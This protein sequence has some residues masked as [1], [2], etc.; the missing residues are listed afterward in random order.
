MARRETRLRVDSEG[1]VE[2]VDPGFDS[3]ALLRELEPGFK[4]RR[5][6]LPSFTS[7]RFLA[8]RSTGCGIALRRLGLEGE[9]T[10]WEAHA[11]V[12]LKSG[13][14]ATVRR[15]GEGEASLLALKIELARRVLSMCRLC[16]HRCHVNR[17]GSEVGVCRLG[18]SATVAEHF[19]HVAE[20]APLNPS[21]VLN[22]YG[23]GLRCRFCQQF[24]L[25]DTA[26]A[27]GDK[28]DAQL[29]AALETGGAR[30]LSF[31]G[32]NPDESLY[33][34]LC[35]LEGAPSDWELPLAWNSHAYS[36][37]ETLSLL[38]GVVDAYV[39]DFKYGAEACGRR[40]SAAPGYREAA[41]KSIATMLGQQVPVMTRLLILPGHFDCCHAPAL[42]FL[43]SCSADNLL[44][45]IRGQYCPDWKVTPED[46]DLARRPRP[47]EVA[48]VISLARR[49]GL[50]TVSGR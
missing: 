17:L 18:S 13:E 4:V 29:W 39:P 2:V 38:D 21:L 6:A 34:I 46:G 44:V 36:T 11:A 26:S 8:A 50:K 35:F 27:V 28:L 49:L 20:E 16:A 3:L 37:P 32:G 25:L 31:V 5:S 33:S 43:A 30:S 40:L 12:I 48:E 1:R 10:L 15:R 45:S 22:L 23:C 7:P 14:S 9:A 42:T 47:G 41:E 19:V 24:A